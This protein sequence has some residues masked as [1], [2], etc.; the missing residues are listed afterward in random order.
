MALQ[1]DVPR[2]LLDAYWV[3]IAYLTKSVLMEI[4]TWAGMG[5]VFAGAVKAKFEVVH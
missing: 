2:R 1:N 4:A 5:L 3:L